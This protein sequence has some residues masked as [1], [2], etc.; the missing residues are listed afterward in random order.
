MPGSV[1][2]PLDTSTFAERALPHAVAIARSAHAALH[3]V[4]V[5]GSLSLDQEGVERDYLG[6]LAAQLESHLLGGITVA[7]LAAQPGRVQYSPPVAE[8][9][10]RPI[11]DY[12]RMHDVDLLVL[13]T[14]GRGGL[15]ATSLGSVA[16]V[17]VRSP[18]RCPVFLVRPT[19][20]PEVGIADAPALKHII[21]AVD[22]SGNAEQA[23]RY[24]LEL[25]GP[26]AAR[27]SLLYV[28]SPLGPAAEDW[29]GSA[30]AAAEYLEQLAARLRAEGADVDT[31]LVRGLSPAPAIVAHAVGERADAIA[32][33]TRGAGSLRRL[34]LGSTTAE[35]VRNSPIP[36]LVCRIRLVHQEADT[37]TAVPG[38]TNLPSP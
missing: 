5:R 21:V 27:Y 20:A 26:F 23:I 16:D 37:G 9:V 14:H 1:L 12:A 10:A 38:T 24:A 31:R 15:R 11:A 29:P 17:L 36:V 19:D 2:V 22:G 18:M 30:D 8:L 25:G 34:L 32:M 7:V 3:L 33:A 35:V 6:N 4:C 13:A 28:Q